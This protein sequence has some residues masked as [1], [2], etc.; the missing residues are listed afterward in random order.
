MNLADIQYLN[1][2]DI[3]LETIILRYKV[4]FKTIFESDY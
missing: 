4:K 3:Q 2:F 1:A